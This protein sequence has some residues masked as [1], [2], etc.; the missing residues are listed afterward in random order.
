MQL[1]EA[2]TPGA[3]ARSEEDCQGIRDDAAARANRSKGR[4]G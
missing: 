1:P 3:F 4:R 2:V